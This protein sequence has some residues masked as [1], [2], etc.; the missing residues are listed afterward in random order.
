MGKKEEIRD[1]FE[2]K[3]CGCR[4]FRPIYTFS[5]RF[6]RVNFSDDL[7]YDRINEER[8]ECTNCGAIYT[9]DE[10]KDALREIKRRRKAGK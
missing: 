8:Y 6:Y 7:I 2:C 1:F 5:L 9:M 4:T 10:I 3:K